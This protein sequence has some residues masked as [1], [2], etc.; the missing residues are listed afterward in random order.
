MKKNIKIITTLI[1]LLLGYLIC[2][3]YKNNIYALNKED[4]LDLLIE[5]RNEQN[6]LQEEISKLNKEIYDKTQIINEIENN[7]TKNNN[8]IVTVSFIANNNS[9]HNENLALKTSLENDIT[10]L[11]DYR[12]EIKKQ[13][14]DY[15]IEGV[16]LE[17][18]I[19]EE[20][21]IYMN[22]N[23]LKYITG[24]WPLES[25]KTIS[26]AFGNRIHPITGKYKFHNGIDIPAPQNTDILSS[27]D[28]TVIFSGTQNGYGNVVKIKHFDGKNTVYA[29]NEYNIAKEGD[30]VKKGQV[31]A[32][33]GSTGNST[34][35]HIHFEIIVNEENINPLKA[36]DK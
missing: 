32:K 20:T 36:V 30:I 23:N 6:N 25:Y 31:I 26:S 28:G 4:K 22:N 1:L 7:F 34:G 19:E 3:G 24:I 12:E 11:T 15:M 5:N 29:H 35:N 2:V 33:V 27:D 10:I 13:L 9:I 18:F 8:D 21:K 17:K 14:E 16:K